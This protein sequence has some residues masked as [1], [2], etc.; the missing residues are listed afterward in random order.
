MLWFFVS[1]KI[2][3]DVQRELLERTGE[4]MSGNISRLVLM[5]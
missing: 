5:I 1:H 2:D 4:V 3:L